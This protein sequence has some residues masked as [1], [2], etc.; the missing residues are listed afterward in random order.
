MYY[1]CCEGVRPLAEPC[2]EVFFDDAGHV[3][4]VA[5]MEPGLGCLALE[6]PPEECEAYRRDPTGMFKASLRRLPGIESRLAG[7]RRHGPIRGSRGI[8]NHCCVPCGPGW[9][10][11]GDAASCKDPITGLGIGDA[12]TQALLLSDALPA[13]FSGGD[14]DPIMQAYQERRGR[15]VMPSYEATVSLAQS[16]AVPR[17]TIGVSAGPIRSGPVPQGAT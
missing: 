1:A 16:S 13:A 11:T 9:A 2:F 12:L 5:R 6:I 10:P 4:F 14:W 17:E 3:G 7:A 15:V 8:E